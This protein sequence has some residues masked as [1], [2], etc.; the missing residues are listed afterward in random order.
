MSDKYNFN[1][2]DFSSEGIERQISILEKILESIKSSDLS[3]ENKRKAI[4]IVEEY[5]NYYLKAGE[6]YK[7]ELLE[8][9][10]SNYAFRCQN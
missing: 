3:L 10:V 9:V 8:I 1:V 4:K 6:K 5:T 2:N 7:K